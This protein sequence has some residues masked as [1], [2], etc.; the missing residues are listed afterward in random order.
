MT[1]P[2]S[3]ASRRHFIKI[4]A[5]G[6]A[7]AAFGGNAHAV[8]AVTEADPTAAAL[9]Y[10]MDATKSADRKDKAAECSNCALY[11]GKAGA[12]DGPCGAFGGKLVKAKGWCSAWAKKP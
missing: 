8:D 12:A 2:S 7:A 10:K 3:P 6:F 5:I 11:T 4:T 9:K 1:T